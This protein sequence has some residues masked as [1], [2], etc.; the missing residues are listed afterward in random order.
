VKEKARLAVLDQATVVAM[1]VDAEAGRAHG[2]GVAAAL[3]EDELVRP[4]AECALDAGEA[5]GA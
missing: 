2:P 4:V 5:D 3:G 1:T